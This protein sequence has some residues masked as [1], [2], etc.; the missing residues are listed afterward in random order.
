MADRVQTIAE[1]DG[2]AVG[3]VIRG[4]LAEHVECQRRDLEF[5]AMMEWNLRRHRGLLSIL[6]DG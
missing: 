6:A 2:T 5:Q 3:D 4:A 1:V